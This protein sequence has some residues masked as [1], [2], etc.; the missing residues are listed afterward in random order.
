MREESK[1][2]NLLCFAYFL[3][4]LIAILLTYYVVTNMV[5][6]D[7]ANCFNNLLILESQGYCRL[8]DSGHN[9]WS[10]QKNICSWYEDILANKT[11]RV[12]KKPSCKFFSET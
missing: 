6:T 7:T 5:Y 11:Q 4:L 2:N 12:A 3:I 8:R 9:Y 10:H 1:I